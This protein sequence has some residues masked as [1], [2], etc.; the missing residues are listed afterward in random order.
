MPVSRRERPS[1][2]LFALIR[3]LARSTRW[4][5]R[6]SAAG[7]DAAPPGVIAKLAA[8]SHPQV[9]YAVLRRDRLPASVLVTLHRKNWD[10]QAAHYHIHQEA[11]AAHRNVPGWVLDELDL[12]HIQVRQTIL[13][14]RNFTPRI[15]AILTLQG[16]L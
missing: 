11:L 16:L 3:S 14:V 9:R 12:D 5:E 2:D 8:D 1:P 4:Q 13:T 15:R 10:P 7:Y 6:I